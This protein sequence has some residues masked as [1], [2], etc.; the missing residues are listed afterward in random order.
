MSWYVWTMCISEIYISQK[1]VIKYNNSIVF[2]V[3]NM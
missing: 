1:L 3:F 2:D